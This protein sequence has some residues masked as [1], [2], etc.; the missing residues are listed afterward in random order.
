MAEIRQLPRAQRRGVGS[1]ADWVAMREAEQEALD[2]VL[3]ADMLAE[4]RQRARSAAVTPPKEAPKRTKP[5]AARS[6]TPRTKAHAAAHSTKPR[7][8][9]EESTPSR[10]TQAHRLG[11]T[12]QHR[13]QRLR[14]VP[15]GAELRHNRRVML[16]ERLIV[17]LSVAFI[18]AGALVSVVVRAEIAKMQLHADTIQP[19][20]SSLNKEN[21]NLTATYQQL[22]APA[23]IA[24]IAQSQLHMVFAPGAGI[25]ATTQPGSTYSAQGQQYSYYYSPS[26]VTPTPPTTATTV[27]PTT[28]TTVAGSAAQASTATTTASQGG[29]KAGPPTTAAASAP[30]T[31]APPTTTPPKSPSTT[32]GRTLVTPP[33]S[34]GGAG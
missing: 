19:V 11:P 9:R 32:S 26:G 7:I 10:R 1:F 22:S 16:A 23:R 2:R 12:A 14:T 13:I 3:T 25:T 8:E 27:P 34:A 24:A 17:L 28:S 29:P 4:H 6:A 15:T 30:P 33:V 18:A 21:A 20:L 31:T 5:R